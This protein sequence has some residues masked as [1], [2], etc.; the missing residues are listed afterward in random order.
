MSRFNNE[1]LLGIINKRG[2]GISRDPCIPG[3]DSKLECGAGNEPLET[4]KIQ[5]S[6]SGKYVV[7]VVSYRS[8]LCDEDNLCEKFG[9]DF[10]RYAGILE[11]DSPDKTH[12]IT[13]QKKCKKSEERTEITIDRLPN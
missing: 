11:K 8:R 3:K 7:R 10:L 5:E 2:Y 13:T 1:Q 9:V 4:V 6:Y 12:I